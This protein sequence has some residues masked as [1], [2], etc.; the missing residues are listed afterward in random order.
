MIA[1]RPKVGGISMRYVIV[2]VMLLAAPRRPGDR[3][4]LHRDRLDR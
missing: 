2:M 1:E 4:G 3:L